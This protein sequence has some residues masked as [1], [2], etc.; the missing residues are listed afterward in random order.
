MGL[1][2]NESSLHFEQAN[3]YVHALDLRTQGRA[4]W[5]NTASIWWF[6]LLGFRTLRHVGTADHL[7]VSLPVR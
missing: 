5:K 1:P 7:H 3:G 6:K 4:V 2:V